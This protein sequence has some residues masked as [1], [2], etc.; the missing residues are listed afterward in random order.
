MK[1]IERI[2][3]KMELRG[4]S[5]SVIVNLIARANNDLFLSADEPEAS[6]EIYFDMYSHNHS[7]EYLQQ[8]T[9]IQVLRAKLYT[10]YFDSTIL[11]QYSDDDLVAQFLHH[12]YAD[13][14]DWLD[15]AMKTIIS[16]EIGRRKL[17]KCK[18]A[19]TI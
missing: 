15:T 9:R 8:Q 17:A 6:S 5:K 3:K 13:Y 16:E 18:Y 12:L 19:V 1:P 11:S 7:L 2:I 4:I 14:P 10:K